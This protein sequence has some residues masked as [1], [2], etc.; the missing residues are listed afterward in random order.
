M[1]YLVSVQFEIEVEDMSEARE[2]MRTMVELSEDTG[3]LTT[4]LVKDGRVVGHVRA[5]R[6]S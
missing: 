6:L 5:E 3:F 2:W 4:A 1:T